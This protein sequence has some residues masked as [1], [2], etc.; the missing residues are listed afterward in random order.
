M[1]MR[2]TLLVFGAALVLGNALQ[3]EQKNRKPPKRAEPAFT[4]FVFS[5]SRGSPDFHK[6]IDKGLEEVVKRVRKNNK[7]F[8]LSESRE[9]TEIIVEILSHVVREEHVNQLMT[10]VN[11]TGIGKSW[12]DD[13]FIREY[14]M[15]EARVSFLGTQKILTGRDERARSGNI[16]NAAANLVKLVE[17]YCKENYW[18]LAEK[19]RRAA[20]RGPS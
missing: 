2:R 8:Q 1:V 12:V 11:Q 13:N 10:R 20:T 5:E 3:A 18:E 15:L 17:S 9:G 6:R 14:H 7:W 4:V 19:R 16:K